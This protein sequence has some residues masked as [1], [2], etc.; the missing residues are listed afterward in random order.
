MFAKSVSETGFGIVRY[1]QQ[2]IYIQ[3]SEFQNL[4]KCYV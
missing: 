4:G 2:S 1:I 3:G